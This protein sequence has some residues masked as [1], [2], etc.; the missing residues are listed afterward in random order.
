MNNPNLITMKGGPQPHT[1]GL[2]IIQLKWIKHRS[3]IHYHER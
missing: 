3:V 1:R 2:F